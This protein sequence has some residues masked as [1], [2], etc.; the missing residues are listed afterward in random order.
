[1]PTCWPPCSPWCT[2]DTDTGQ[3]QVRAATINAIRLRTPDG[4]F[5][6]S[7]TAGGA[8]LVAATVAAPGAAETFLFASGMSGPRRSGDAIELWACNAS[9]GASSAQLRVEHSV[10]VLPRSGKNAPPLVTYE[11]GGPGMAVFVNAGFS[12]GYPAY[13][14]NDPAEW[15]FDILKAGG[16]P[17]ADGDAVSLRINSNLGRTFFFRVTG[18]QSGAVVN[19]DGTSQGAAGTVFIATFN[20]VLPGA[21][22]RPTVVVCRTC[23]DIVGSV[24]NQSSKAPIANAVV[25]ALDVIENHPFAGTTGL[26]GGFAL[27]DPEGR[28]CVPSGTVRLSARA[29]RH[30]TKIHGPVAV[31]AAG[32]I[33]VT[34]ELDCTIVSGFVVDQ[35]NRLLAGVAVALVDANR[36]PIL[37]SD[38]QPLVT[39][40]DMNGVFIFRCVPH[41][42]V[43]AW[44][45]SEPARLHRIDVP[46]EGRSNV[47]I[48]TQSVC[49]NLIGTVRNAVTLAAIPM[50]RVSIIGQTQTTQTNATGEFRLQCVQPAG[51]A[52]LLAGAVGFTFGAG[53]GTVPMS[54][55]SAPVDIQLQPLPVSALAMRL[56][57]GALPGDLDLRLT[58]P[59]NMGGRFH[60]M[61]AFPAPVSYA[62]LD[63][64]VRTGFGPE[65]I[66]V[67]P[68]IVGTFVPG[69][70]RVAVFNVGHLNGA[71]F[72]MSNAVVT[73]VTTGA[74][75][76]N[77][78]GRFDVADAAGP[79]DLPVW[80]VC[81]FDVTANG[82]VTVTP[83]QA[84]VATV[85]P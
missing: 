57:W 78:I 37:G 3:C 44:L 8:L 77:Q 23:A 29:D 73:I 19:G 39:T 60:V 43:F 16:G 68:L 31:P 27:A 47:A 34:I 11:I 56:D 48:V 84:L 18:S 59:N 62:Q 2:C 6:Q 46:P 63:Q 71:R 64:D 36:A 61:W 76:M 85:P 21:G 51:L 54:G 33:N 4:R 14:A 80:H 69:L 83:I 81:D 49:G 13:R 1:M 15:T 26:N 20:E 7:P 52:H 5:L 58:G 42:T 79:Q 25:E 30:Q 82:V 28:T 45:M 65:T 74:L 50:A 66:T 55:D 53:F 9:F 17:I 32:T 24:V 75:G 10:V 72:D 38:G 35:F 22:W 67:T 41:G 40:T 70:Y 12:P